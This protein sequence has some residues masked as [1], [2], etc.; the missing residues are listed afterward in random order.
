MIAATAA[1]LASRLAV[2]T[3]LVAGFLHRVH[4]VPPAYLRFALRGAAALLGLAALAGRGVPEAVLL[5]ALALSA[6]WLGRKSARAGNG[7]LVAGLGA[8]GAISMPLLASPPAPLI[9][10]AA[11]ASGAFLLGAVAATMLLGHWYLV[12]TSLSIRPLAVGALLVEAGA[13]AR[14]AV[15]ALILATGGYEALRLL[16]PE[17]IIYSTNALFF[18][19]RTVTGLLAPVVLAFLIRRTVRIRSTQS[20]TG[21]LYVALILTLFGE[22]TAAFLEMVTGGRLA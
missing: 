19:F 22:L 6:L 9:A 5:A 20:A 2:G 13:W 21:L 16:R 18:S 12:D 4:P 3:L 10:V 17:D 1:L 11:G 15:V 7:L 8:A 14:M